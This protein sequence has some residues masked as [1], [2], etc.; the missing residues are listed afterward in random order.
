LNHCPDLQSFRCEKK[1][2]STKNEKNPT[3]TDI[4]AKLLVLDRRSHFKESRSFDERKVLPESDKNDP[5]LS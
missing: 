3:T 1:G 2:I 5:R 4:M